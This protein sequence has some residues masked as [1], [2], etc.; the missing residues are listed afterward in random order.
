M[1][2][3]DTVGKAGIKNRGKEL[4]FKQKKS[5]YFIEEEEGKDR[6][7]PGGFVQRVLESEPKHLAGVPNPMSWTG[8]SLWPVRN[9]A[10]QQ[11]VS[12]WQ[13]RG[14]SSVFTAVPHCLHYRIITMHNVIVIEIKYT[15]NVIHL[16]NPETIPPSP[17][18]E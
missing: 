9:Q 1:Q 10:T 17:S 13:A 3:A 14:A 8:T 5:P 2:I 18:L 12:S 6:T 7:N 15:I 11:E 16:N 4:I